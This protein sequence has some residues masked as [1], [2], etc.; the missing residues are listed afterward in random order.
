MIGRIRA[1]SSG[2]DLTIM[3]LSSTDLPQTLAKVRA[4]GIG[5]YV[6]KPVKR[7]ELYAAIAEAMADRAPVKAP[8]AS[9]AL[10]VNQPETFLQLPL[11]ILLADDSADNRLLIR[12][13]LRKTP[14]HLEE[15]EDGAKAV[16]LDSSR[17]TTILC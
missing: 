16:E 10:G 1:M 14:Y 11:R 2:S 6:V 5:W 4:L 13:Y 7:A 3:M 9:Q 17:A 8:I 15:A 12:A